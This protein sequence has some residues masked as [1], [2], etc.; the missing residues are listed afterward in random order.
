MQAKWNYILRNVEEAVRKI[1]GIRGRENGGKG[2]G[3]R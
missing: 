2:R 1:Q 3:K